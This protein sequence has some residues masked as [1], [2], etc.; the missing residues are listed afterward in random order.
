MYHLFA[1]CGATNKL[2]GPES[3]EA[4]SDSSRH[5]PHASPLSRTLTCHIRLGLPT[6]QELLEDGLA[7]R[8]E[9]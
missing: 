7:V 3:P 2:Q 8:A 5:M 1:T 9:G 6:V 4:E